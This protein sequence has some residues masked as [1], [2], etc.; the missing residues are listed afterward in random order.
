MLLF[1]TLQV[2]DHEIRAN[3]A[4]IHLA[5][6]YGKVNPLDE[7][8]AGRFEEWQSW[9]RRKNFKRAQVVSLISLPA[10]NRWLFAGAYDSR[11]WIKA[12]DERHAKARDGL[13]KYTLVER[14]NAEKLKGRLIVEFGRSGRAPYLDAERWAD[15]LEV[16]EMLPERLSIGDFPG[17]ARVHLSK[18]DLDL[19]VRHEMASWKSALA[20][21]AGV[22]VIS[23]TNTGKLYVGSATGEGG[24]WASWSTYSASGHGGNKELR[25]L[26]KERGSEHVRHFQFAILETADTKTGEDEI[27]HRESHWKRVLLSREPYGYNA[28]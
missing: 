8:F 23:D 2:V 3:D 16:V 26:L 24:L 25:K 14:P 9:Q 19:V 10:A 27:L 15:S 6:S 28:N 18:A 12:R 20:S 17:Y 11:G 1:P 5:T 21:V 7:F 4:K 22:Y 13:Y